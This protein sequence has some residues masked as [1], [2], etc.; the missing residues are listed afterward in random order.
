MCNPSNPY[1]PVIQVRTSAA[2]G[3]MAFQPEI[4]TILKEVAPD[5]KRVF[6]ID[7]GYITYNPQSL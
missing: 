7:S 5:A 1:N 4:E 3:T 2:S 6:L